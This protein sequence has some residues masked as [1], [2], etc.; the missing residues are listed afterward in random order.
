M[1]AAG[2]LLILCQLSCGDTKTII[3][4]TLTGVPDS[5]ASLRVNAF[6]DRLPTQEPPS[7]IRKPP[8]A[9]LTYFRAEVP[10]SEV[11]ELRLDVLVLDGDEC[12]VA[13]GES[14]LTLAGPGTYDV[15][16]EVKATT[17]CQLVLNKVGEGAGSVTVINGTSQQSYTFDRPPQEMPSCPLA[18]N[19]P[20]SQTLKFPIRTH[21]RLMAS[22]ADES[23]HGSLFGSWGDG[24][25]GRGGCEFDISEVQ[26]KVSVSF[27]SS[28][29][30]TSSGVC[31]RHPLPQGN[32]LRRVAGRNAVDVWAVG[33]R[34]TI[35]RWNGS[36]WTSPRRPFEV[37]ALNSVWAEA[38]PGTSLMA[39]GEQGVTRALSQE[40]WACSQSAGTSAL[41]DVWGTAFSDIWAVGD[42]GTLAHWDGSKWTLVTSP[43]GPT[44]GLNAVLGRDAK[45]AWAVGEMGTVL[46]YDGTTWSRVPVPITGTLNGLWQ[47]LGGDVWA[48]GDNGVSLLLTSRSGSVMAEVKPTGTTV[49]LHG[50]WGA[51]PNEIWAAGAFGTI[52]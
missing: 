51:G 12:A 35:V 45:D 11:G 3:L 14:T 24:C 17:G 49:R 38:V 48:V 40:V 23:L 34:G 47:D 2:V 30:C 32:T 18:A 50:I 31:W 26:T 27:Y 7:E 28:T 6:L 29:L 10:V 52:L 9:S 4:A 42:K 5:A 36:Y 44:I 46:R 25:G 41:R 21:L 22:V 19:Y 33:D 16:I 8:A 43:A 1:L 20:S 39:V 13:R 37:S 15:A